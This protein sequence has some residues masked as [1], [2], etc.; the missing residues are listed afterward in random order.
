MTQVTGAALGQKRLDWRVSLECSIKKIPTAIPQP[1]LLLLNPRHTSKLDIV[2]VSHRSD[3]CHHLSK[4][5]KK[6]PLVRIPSFQTFRALA[7]RFAHSV[8]DRTAGPYARTSRYRPASRPLSPAEEGRKRR[9]GPSRC[10]T[11]GS[12]MLEEANG[13]ACL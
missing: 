9:Y 13:C 12:A 10:F 2:K 4:C 7:K 11:L 8:A 3:P 5:L 6:P 1:Q